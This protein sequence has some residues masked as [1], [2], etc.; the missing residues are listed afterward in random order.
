M[1]ISLRWDDKVLS[2]SSL[3]LQEV[4]GRWTLGHLAVISLRAAEMKLVKN[5]AM[6]PSNNIWSS[7]KTGPTATAA[8]L[9]SKS[10]QP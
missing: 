2:S 4:K 5:E 3:E 8:L 10:T 7:L 6:L 9:I 1:Q